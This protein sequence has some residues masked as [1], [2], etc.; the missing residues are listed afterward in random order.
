MEIHPDFKIPI[1]KS[2]EEYLNKAKEY[3]KYLDLFIKNNPDHNIDFSKCKKRDHYIGFGT[4]EK[5]WEL[6]NN[7]VEILKKEIVTLKKELTKHR[8]LK[9]TLIKNDQI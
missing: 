4:F 8:K 6:K 9:L 1:Y 7:E 2:K 5:G 3:L